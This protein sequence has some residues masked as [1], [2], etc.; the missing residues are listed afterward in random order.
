[1]KQVATDIITLLTNPPPYTVTSLQFF[2]DTKKSLLKIALILNRTD[3]TQDSLPNKKKSN[4]SSAVK[5]VTKKT[6]NIVQP[7]APLLIK[8]MTPIK[9]NPTLLSHAEETSLQQKALRNTLSHLESFIKERGGN[10]APQ[11]R[12]PNRFKQQSSFRIIAI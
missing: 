11:P 7:Q 8:Q 4:L 5:L 9:Y 10:E 1:M 12:S 6:T 2:D 3:G